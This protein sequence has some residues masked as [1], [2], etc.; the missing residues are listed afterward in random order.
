[1]RLSS[2]GCLQPWQT[3]AVGIRVPLAAF[4]SAFLRVGISWKVEGQL[5]GAVCCWAVIFGNFFSRWPV[6]LSLA[7]L[8]QG[9][10]LAIFLPSS[11]RFL[12]PVVPAGALI[13]FATRTLVNPAAQ[14]RYTLI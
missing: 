13:S 2:P 12:R 4:E 9:H 11:C 1:M 14:F 8:G 7:W 6:F 3:K 5:S 10:L